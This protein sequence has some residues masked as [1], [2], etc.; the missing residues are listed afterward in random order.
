MGIARHLACYIRVFVVKLIFRIQ[1]RLTN[2]DVLSTLSSKLNYH[3]HNVGARGTAIM[4][5]AFK[6]AADPA[7]P[8]KYAPRWARERPQSVLVKDEPPMGRPLRSCDDTSTFTKDFAVNLRHR[9]SLEPELVSQPKCLKEHS[10]ALTALRLTGLTVIAAL[11][12]SIVVLLPA[13]R[14]RSGIKDVDSALLAN[15]ANNL[16]RHAADLVQSTSLSSSVPRLSRITSLPDGDGI[17][18]LIKLG[19]D[20]LQNG[21]FSAARLLLMRAAEA[22]SADAALAVGETFDPLVIQQLHGIGVQS[23]PAKA[24][25]WYERAVQLGSDAALQRLAKLAQAP[26]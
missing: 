21:D 20:F 24:R 22:G 19:Q 2:L 16:A 1:I 4:D 14:Q 17:A 8:L 9:V 6:P 26:Q 25:E 10:A 18:T 7:G 15:G 3:R 12:A 13:M 23:D 11:I 5:I